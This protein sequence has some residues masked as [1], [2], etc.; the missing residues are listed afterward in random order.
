MSRLACCCLP[1]ALP[2]C[3]PLPAEAGRPALAAPSPSLAVIAAA[4]GFA[5][6]PRP[7]IERVPASPGRV[8]IGKGTSLDA[9]L[10]EPA[11]DRAREMTDARR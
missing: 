10:F 9:R 1:L 2:G 6:V 4:T 3:T 11:R 8:P 7:R 5:I